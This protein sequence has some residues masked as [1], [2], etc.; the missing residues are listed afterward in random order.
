MS[1]QA[2]EQ[3]VSVI[4]PVRNEG[5]FIDRSLGAV[6][7]QDYP[8]DLMEVLVVDG[9]SA[10][11]TRERVFEIQKRNPQVQLLDN[12]GKIV[13]TGLN[14]ALR[15]ARGEIIVRVDGHCEIA[16]DYVRKCVEHLRSGDADG[17]GGPIE[18]IG[19]TTWARAIAEAMSSSFGVGNSAFRT[20]KDRTMLV[21]TVPFPG[22]TR[23]AIE[24]AGYFDEELVRNQDDEYNYRLRK[25][26]G[27]ILLTPDIRSRYYSRTSLRSLWRQ[28]LQY[29]YWKVRVM[30]K[31]PLQMRL[32]QFVPALFVVVLLIGVLLAPF[33]SGVRLLLFAVLAFYLLGAVAAS[34]MVA[35]R[36]SWQLVPYLLVSFGILHIAYGVGFIGGL[37]RFWNRWSTHS[38]NHAQRE[39]AV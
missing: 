2:E 37:V 28:Y 1:S 20:T 19:E 5:P 13:P 22:Y 36:S 32:R 18:T 26:G 33:L 14:I 35:R 29:G 38:L 34:L 7:D 4:M 3:F 27:K 23:A 8:A 16:P 31:H 17:V 24:K 25:L 9:L 21:D 39:T 15:R 6:L 11:G 30:Q 10:D 12:P